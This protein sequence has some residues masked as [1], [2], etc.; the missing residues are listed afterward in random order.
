MGHDE[1]HGA[2]FSRPS[3]TRLQTKSTAFHVVKSPNKGAAG[4][5]EF[6]R[7]IHSPSAGGVRQF[8]QV[9]GARRAEQ[10]R[11]EDRACKNSFGESMVAARLDRTGSANSSSLAASVPNQ[12]GPVETWKTGGKVGIETINRVESGITR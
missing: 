4:R 11:D 12:R 10:V 8:T 2:K 6:P 5:T 7:P 9:R 1:V 3:G